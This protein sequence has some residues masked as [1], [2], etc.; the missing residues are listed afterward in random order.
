MFIEFLSIISRKSDEELRRITFHKG[1]NLVVDS[2]DSERHNHVGKTTF[3]RLID[4]LLGSDKRKSIYTDAENGAV[5]KA[6]EQFIAT[7][8]ISIEGRLSSD[9]PSG[10]TSRTMFLRVDLFRRGARYIDG[11]K[12]NISV[13]SRIS[14][15]MTRGRPRHS[16]S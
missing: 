3:L 1:T 2:E 16:G 9:L 8:R 7:E 14:C 5:N 6:L 15:S 12:V 4:V 11:E 13:G 10:K